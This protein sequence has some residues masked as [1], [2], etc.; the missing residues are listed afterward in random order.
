MQEVAQKAR[1]CAQPIIEGLGYELVDV[2][3]VREDGL[4]CLNYYIYK[5]EGVTLNDC[6][7]VSH[8]IDEAVEKADPTGGAQYCLCVCSPGDRP[9]LTR[10]DFER[11][12]GTEVTIELKMPIRG[13]KKKLTGIL[14]AFDEKTITL[15]GKKEEITVNRENICTVRP[16]FGF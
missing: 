5:P 1:Q 9:L 2:E 8:A 10:R 6:E 11:N 3:F 13:K 12:I 7:T 15:A 14:N 4:M 16:Y